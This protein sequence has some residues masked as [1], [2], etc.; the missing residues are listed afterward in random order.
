MLF[1]EFCSLDSELHEFQDAFALT[2]TPVKTLGHFRIAERMDIDGE[3][4]D[5]EASTYT[6]TKKTARLRRLRVC[7]KT[8]YLDKVYLHTL[9]MSCG[10][11]YSAKFSTMIR[12]PVVGFRLRLWRI[13]I[14]LVLAVSKLKF[15]VR[16]G[17]N[18]REEVLLEGL[19]SIIFGWHG[20]LFFYKKKKKKK[21]PCELKTLRSCWYGQCWTNRKS[22]FMSVK[23]SAS[24]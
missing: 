1:E 19:S 17:Y 12:E 9:P 22:F 6:N 16:I 24:T 2:L 4:S 8:M 20:L 18:R 13:S 11:R 3:P 21:S 23:V 15:K 10:E 5:F 7:I 14:S